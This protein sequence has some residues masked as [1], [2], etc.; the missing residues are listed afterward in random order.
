MTSAKAYTDEKVANLLENSTEAVDSIYEL[1]DAMNDNADAIEALQ[2]IAGNKASKTEFDAHVSDTTKH[3]TSTERTNWGTAYTHS[4]STHAPSDAQAN[5]IE[6]IKVNGTAQTITS[7]AVNITVP[8]KASDI[9]AAA[10]SHAHA[11]S[12]ITNL[13]TTLNNAASAISSNTSSID[14]HT[15]RISALE[16]KVGDG[17]EEITSADIQKLFAQ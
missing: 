13:Q 1:R 10:S 9:G 6:S 4:Q 12:D 7:K 2:T 5:V 14:A 8:T 11:I 16:D 15:D 17:F 3:I